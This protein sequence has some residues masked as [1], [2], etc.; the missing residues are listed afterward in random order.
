[1]QLTVERV[2]EMAKPAT[3]P[4]LEGKIGQAESCGESSDLCVGH[5][6][7]QPIQLS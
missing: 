3:Q 6:A 1:M 2:R 5:D 7:T 4:S